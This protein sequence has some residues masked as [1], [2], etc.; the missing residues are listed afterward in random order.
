MRVTLDIPDKCALLFSQNEIEKEFKLYAALMLLKKGKISVS[1][2][3]ELADISIYDFLSSCK[4]FEIPV[5]NFSKEELEGE[6][7]SFHL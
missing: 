6:L 1:R 3:A 5:L 7:A 2:G 4:E